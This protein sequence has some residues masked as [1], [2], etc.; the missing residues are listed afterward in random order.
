MLFLTIS[1]IIDSASR[2]PINE[3]DISFIFE[4]LHR[5]RSI[6]PPHDINRPTLVRWDPRLPLSLEN[7]V[8]FESKE[9]ERHIREC[10]DTTGLPKQN[11]NPDKVWGEEVTSIVER[12]RLEAAKVKKWIL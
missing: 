7:C 11:V 8:V 9:A 2:L 1:L 6:V 3:D 10:W 5:G 4:D 12:R